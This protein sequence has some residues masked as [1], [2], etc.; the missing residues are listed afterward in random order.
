MG[1]PKLITI[2]GQQK[3]TCTSIFYT[4][5]NNLAIFEL[6]I[7]AFACLCSSPNINLTYCL[8]VHGGWSS[9]SQ[10][11]KTCKDG[12]VQSR[13]CT[14]PIPKYGGKSCS[15]ST[16]QKCNQHIDC[17]KY[18]GSTFLD[19]LNDARSFLFIRINHIV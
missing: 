14:N 12:A 1:Q 2:K 16:S 10:C 17:R 19:L 4:K 11:S 5:L 7:L 18:L 6:Q 8:A 3:N 9:W 13:T 15:G